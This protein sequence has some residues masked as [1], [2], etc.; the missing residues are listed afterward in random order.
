MFASA[1]RLLLL[2][3][4]IVQAAALFSSL[5]WQFKTASAARNKLRS[6]AAFAHRP[7]GGKYFFVVEHSQLVAWAHGLRTLSTRQSITW[8]GHELRQA[9]FLCSRIRCHAGMADCR[10]LLADA[11]PDEDAHRPVAMAGICFVSGSCIIPVFRRCGNCARIFKAL[12]R[13]SRLIAFIT[14]FVCLYVIA[15][16]ETWNIVRYRRMRTALQ[17]MD[18]VRFFEICPRWIPTFFLALSCGLC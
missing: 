18:Y 15:F 4:L 8:Y 14:G 17:E 16:Q 3:G 12:H 13:F 6:I 5:A 1:L 9:R 10:H 7:R 11:R 2:S